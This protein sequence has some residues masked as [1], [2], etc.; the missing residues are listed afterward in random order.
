[1]YRAYLY[2]DGGSDDGPGQEL[3]E[4]VALSK[5]FPLSRAV[6]CDARGRSTQIAETQAHREGGIAGRLL[7]TCYRNGQTPPHSVQLTG[8][9]T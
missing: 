2:P 3:T 4:R 5:R 6:A 9:L 8:Q 7:L 1:M